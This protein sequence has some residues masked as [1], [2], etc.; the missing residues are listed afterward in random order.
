MKNIIIKTLF[1]I[2]TILVAIVG[3]SKDDEKETAISFLKSMYEVNDYENYERSVD[4]RNKGE[5]GKF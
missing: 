1:L 4:I 2:I 3:C 5:D